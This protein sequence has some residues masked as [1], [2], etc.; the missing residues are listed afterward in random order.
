MQENNHID[1]PSQPKLDFLL[2]SSTIK[3][4]KIEIYD[5][6]TQNDPDYD[7]PDKEKGWRQPI[8][9]IVEQAW[10]KANPL[11]GKRMLILDTPKLLEW[12][13]LEKMGGEERNLTIVERD[14]K[15]AA[16][17]TGIQA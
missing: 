4:R 8:A 9:N 15:K 17:P 2:Q 3:K 10:G 11:R 14:K 5:S 1:S 6:G 7:N 13:M 12:R 16:R